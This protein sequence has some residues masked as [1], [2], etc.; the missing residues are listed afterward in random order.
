MTDFKRRCARR[1]LPSLPRLRGRVR[2]GA[3]PRDAVNP[4]RTGDVLQ[5]LVAQIVEGKVEP[6]GGV[7]LDP[8][9]D[10]DPAGVGQGF[11][12]GGDVDPVAENVAVLDNNVAL[13]DP[14]A[15]F[16]STFLG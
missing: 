15:E 13:V 4:H 6:A 14:D 10:A 9:R 1:P 7:L 11:E 3:F 8:G 5:L 2:E 16:D 12:A